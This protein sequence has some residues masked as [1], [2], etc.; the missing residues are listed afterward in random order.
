MPSTDV[1]GVETIGIAVAAPA[2]KAK[3]HLGWFVEHIQR[4]GPIECE[5]WNQ[6]QSNAT[7]ETNLQCTHRSANESWSRSRRGLLHAGLG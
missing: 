7:P 5:E 4:A 6:R 1:H 2:T 3:S